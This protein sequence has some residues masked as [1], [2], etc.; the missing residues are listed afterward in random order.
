MRLTAFARRS[1]L[2]AVVLSHPVLMAGPL[3]S[4]IDAR[5]TTQ[6]EAAQSQERID[7]LADQTRAMLQDYQHVTAQAEELRV[8][9]DQ[10]AR[11]VQ[12]QKTKLADF[13]RQLETVRETQ[14]EIVPFMLRM[15]EVLEQVVALDAP[16]LLEERKARLA[17]LKTMMDDPEV[18]LPEKYRRLMEAYQVETE[19][20]RTLEAYSGALELN[21]KR[22]S[23][24]FLRA[25][26]VALVYATLDGG[27]TGY[28]DQAG[29][30]WQ[31]L[32]G[33]YGEPVIQALRVARK[34]AP[35]DLIRLPVAAAEGLTP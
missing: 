18:E 1:V 13:E 16:F 28:W 30:R 20:G 12:N 23:V 29:R 7:T 5:V 26:R 8:F 9:D 14:R 22:R 27:E 31:I 35:P 11:Q 24:D 25:G 33:E 4:A 15:L 21:G 32:P 2:T 19:Y 34:Q 17:G 3:E 10:L 6:K